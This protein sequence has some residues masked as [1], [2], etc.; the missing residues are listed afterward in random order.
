MKNSL[1]IKNGINI[2]EN[3]LEITTSRSGGPGGQHVNKTNTRVTV[4][5]NIKNTNVLTP[6]KKEMVLK[7]LGNQITLD[8]DLIVHNNSS[9]S[10]IK[11]KEMAFET[12]AQKIR[13]A[14]YVPKKR[15]KTNVTKSAKENRLQKKSHK[16]LIK[17]TRSK[18]I[19]FD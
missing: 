3:E 13:K 18:K 9:R 19:V 5:W 6:E 2:P 4:R 8:G 1:Y 16:S 10:Q 12:L 17:K 15:I 7:N 14:L 11:N